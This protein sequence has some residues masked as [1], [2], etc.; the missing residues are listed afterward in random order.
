MVKETVFYDLL[1]VQPNASSEDLKKAYKKMA[2]KYHPDKNPN[3]GERFKQ[4]SMAYEVL[5]DPEKRQ[6]YDEGGESAIKKGGAGGGGP[7]FMS[8]MDIFEMFINGGMRSG[9]R[10]ERRG[11]IIEHILNVTL[12]ELYNGAVRKLA[13]Q[14]IVICD[15]C[16]GRGGK[17]GC[18]SKCQTCRG[19][20]SEIRI[21]QIFPGM[22][23]QV[24]QI[25]RQ[26]SG[27]GE[28]IA[29]KDRCK[30][31]NGKKTI[32]D[33]NVL[34]VHIEKGMQHG[35]K[36]V[37]SGQGNQESPDIE[38]GDISVVLNEKKHSV[39]KRLELDLLLTL[40]IILTE[41]LCGFRKIIKTLDNRDL[42]ITHLPGQ[43]IKT[44]DIKCVMGEGMP[45][46]KNPFEKGRLI[47]NFEVIFPTF[48]APE[49]IPKLETCLPPRPRID[50]SMDSDSMEECTLV[51]YNPEQDNRQRR[52]QQA[53]EE[54]DDGYNQGPRIQQCTTS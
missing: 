5:T 20:G 40:P 43:V 33:R 3:E 18:V 17:K 41:S 1:G 22:V 6:I 46:Y 12:E 21:H 11:K 27:L 32:R 53:Y 47:L 24:E 16:E 31:C 9:G 28:T 8:P 51:D 29:T 26:C 48:I 10:R 42:L 44:G 39:Y 38:P 7:G 19:T 14:K 23:Q 25:C 34:E 45:Q 50:I 54:D 35:Q 13:L 15:K 52:S 4:I 2:L 37:F 36:I 30:Q 49:L